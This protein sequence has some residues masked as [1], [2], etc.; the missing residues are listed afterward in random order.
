MNLKETKEFLIE[1]Q[2]K[3]NVA[4]IDPQLVEKILLDRKNVL[5][6]NILVCIDVSGSISRKQYTMFMQQLN[7]FKGLS[8]I[9]V[10]ET[11]TKIVAMYDYC[12]VE[13]HKVVRLKGGGGTDFR[14]A[15]NKANQ[16]Q[17]DALI[18]MTDGK[19]VNNVLE[20]TYPVGWYLTKNGSI[21]Y[22]FGT[23]LDKFE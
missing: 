15:F 1:I 16:M 8:R 7:H 6:L 5:N 12:T 20:P 4:H 9:K 10:I 2:K 23:L 11:D 21:P 22:D 14:E 13:P 3:K 18:F 19:T 17:P